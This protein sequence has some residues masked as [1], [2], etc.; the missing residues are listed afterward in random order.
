MPCFTHDY[1][2]VDPR[3]C[4]VLP[5]TMPC[6]THDHAMLYP[7]LS[8]LRRLPMAI[9]APATTCTL[10]HT[11]VY[12]LLHTH[13]HVPS[14]HSRSVFPVC[15]QAGIL[16]VFT[17][18]TQNTQ[19]LAFA[20]YLP[21]GYLGTNTPLTSP[22]SLCRQAPYFPHYQQRCLGSLLLRL[23]RIATTCTLIHTPV[24]SLL[25]TPSSHHPIPLSQSTSYKTLLPLCG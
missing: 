18:F 24:Y 9:G 4:H 13:S 6:F 12:S 20:P 17:L 5:M 3:P 25:H 2:M 11:S 1:A 23:G 14:S 10:M 7:R 15:R 16:F 22:Y 8:L 21:S 19:T